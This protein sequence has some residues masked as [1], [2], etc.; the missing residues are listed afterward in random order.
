MCRKRRQLSVL[1]PPGNKWVRGTGG[2]LVCSILNAPPVN[3]GKTLIVELSPVGSTSYVERKPYI[4]RGG[5][6]DIV[7][8]GRDLVP[9]KFCAS[10][11]LSPPHTA[12]H[13]L[14]SPQTGSPSAPSAPF[15]ALTPPPRMQVQ[16]RLRWRT[17][18]L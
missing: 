6:A 15:A 9:G 14:T 5:D 8:S 2:A 10:S 11:T 13:P 16:T 18:T 7:F 3:A 17:L 12:A 4:A 1:A